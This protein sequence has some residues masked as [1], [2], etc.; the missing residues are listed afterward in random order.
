MN[1]SFNWCLPI[2]ILFGF[3]IINA[4]GN[5]GHGGHYNPD[6]L[7]L[8]TV[9]GYAIVDTTFLHPMYY[10]DEDNDGVEE[11]HLNF[12]PYWYSPDSSN[13]S[14]PSDGEFITITGGLID[15][16]MINFPAIIVYEINGEFWR[17][18]YNPFWNHMGY[19][20]ANGGHHMDSCYNSGFG[21]QHDPP[22]TINVT[23]ITFID[24]T[25]MMEHYYLDEDNDSI[26][27]YF[28]NFGPPWYVPPSGAQR[29][30]DGEQV[31][32]VGGLIENGNYSMIIVYEINGMLWRD[33]TF[34][35]GHIGG[36]WM[37]R[38]MNQSF[39]FHTPYDEM[40]WVEM[41]PGWHNGGGHHGGMHDSLFCQ[42]FESVPGRMSTIGNENAFAGYEVDF[43]FPRMMG[44][45]MNHGMG[46][47][48]HIQFNS[49]ANFQFHYSDEQ[50]SINDI[51]EQT[52]QVKFWD[53]DIN[54]WVE[55]S[56]A[57]VNISTNTISFSSDRL[58][59]FYILTGD[60]PTGINDESVL[61][62][63]DFMLEQ[64][65]PNP[66]NPTTAIKYQ[67]PELSFVTLKIF[68]LLGEEIITLVNE[69]IEAG[70]YEVE[71][72]ATNLPSGIYF[73]KLQTPNFTQTKKMILLK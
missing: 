7:E 22:Q 54:T 57:F 29:P 1:K 12:G 31:D 10:I 41:S 51:N 42:I 55:L 26:P 13:A 35:S 2:L 19:H 37:H 3:G 36:G 11:Y 67:I 50:L 23:G 8:V 49:D 53:S 46:C 56:N 18:P 21:W 17:D 28:L 38:N 5:H 66:F 71:F 32:I 45:G 9:D 58:G 60:S 61:V 62:I 14:R 4:Q 65:Y 48:G 40:D 15:S 44:G 70:S 63:T 73:Y 68:S 39:K 72:D 16:T 25:F 24:T 64:N 47:G 33:S 20:G 34:F 6:S 30:Q 59:N 52:I 27:N 69:K 43:Y